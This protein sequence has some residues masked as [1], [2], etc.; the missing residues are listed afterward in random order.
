MR[1]LAPTSAS[2][3]FSPLMLSPKRRSEP[4]AAEPEQDQLPAVRRGQDCPL[5][6][7]CRSGPLL[8]IS[9]S[10]PAQQALGGGSETSPTL[11]GDR[12][13][14]HP[15]NDLAIGERC[16]HRVI[17]AAP[18]GA[19]ARSL[20]TA[21]TRAPPVVGVIALPR[22][23]PSR[24]RPRDCSSSSIPTAVGPVRSGSSTSSGPR[25]PTSR[26]ACRPQ[27]LSASS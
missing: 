21:S 3:K 7:D 1:L 6:W 16:R 18:R 14:P 20:S 24:G 8:R 15:A 19:V 23:R 25:R 26:G 27:W 4:V 13:V 5:T 17:S 10:R 2:S 9:R 11:A 12:S 22:F